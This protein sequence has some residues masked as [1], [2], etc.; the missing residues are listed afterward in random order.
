MKLKYIFTVY[1]E[2]TVHFN[3]ILIVPMN[4]NDI[5]LL[6]KLLLKKVHSCSCIQLLRLLKALYVKHNI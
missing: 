2:I 4:L 6:L 1:L 3:M 5:N